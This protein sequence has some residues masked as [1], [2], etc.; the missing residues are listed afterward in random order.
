MG[1]K[2]YKIVGFLM[3][4]MGVLCG[5]GQKKVP[6]TQIPAVGID[7]VY[8]GFDSA[9]DY[10]DPE[11]ALQDGYYVVVCNDKE[12]SDSLYGG[13]EYWNEFL[14]D[15]EQGREA[16][17]RIASF[18]DGK[19]YE[20]HLIYSDGYYY[21]FHAEQEDLTCRPYQYLR[22]LTGRDGIPKKDVTWFVLTDS[23]ELTYEQAALRFYSSSLEEIK[24]IPDY[25]WLGFTIYLPDYN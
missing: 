21:Y 13:A 23:L 15:S 17:L 2:N 9:K 24:S 3:L 6:S 25:Q 20:S 18:I 10:Q 19:F 14:E 11:K 12:D 16:F 8:E 7:V 4:L 5:C 22:K 1:K